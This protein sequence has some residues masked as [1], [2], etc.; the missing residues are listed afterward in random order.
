[1]SARK[2]KKISN[3]SRKSNIAPHFPH[4]H[5]FFSCFAPVGL[6]YPFN[7]APN[8]L[9]ATIY[10]FTDAKSVS[11]F[12]HL[13]DFICLSLS[14]FAIPC[15]AV[16]TSPLFYCHFAM[17]RPR[18]VRHEARESVCVCVF[19]FSPSSPAPLP[20]SCALSTTYISLQ[21]PPINF[22]YFFPS[23]FHPSH[24]FR[25]C[26]AASFSLSFL[27]S[28]LCHRSPSV[29]R[30]LIVG[31]L[32]LPHGNGFENICRHKVVYWLPKELVDCEIYV[33]I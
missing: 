1:M 2:R 20:I 24:S 15:C 5:L 25:H 12:L 3:N 17:L 19:S 33:F 21:S 7:N 4:A 27:H 23:S 28:T 6:A 26:C 13:A 18:Y 11:L 30:L 31:S 14:H 9:R 16:V 10:I 8:M 22:I 32:I 29:R